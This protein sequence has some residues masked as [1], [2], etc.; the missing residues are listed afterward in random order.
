MMSIFIAVDFETAAYRADSAC[1]VGLMRVENWQV[2]ARVSR[3][4]RPPISTELPV[5]PSAEL[6]QETKC[7]RDTHRPSSAAPPQ[8][9]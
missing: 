7:I 3:L 8:V 5:A 2:T 1:A 4:I 6:A 9:R